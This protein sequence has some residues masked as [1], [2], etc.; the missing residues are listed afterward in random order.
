MSPKNETGEVRQAHRFDEAALADYLKR[1]ISGFSGNLMIRQF[2]YGQSNPTFLL[3]AGERSYVLRKKPPGKL[4]PSA[5]A[6]DREYRMIQALKET[7]VPVAEPLLFCEDASIIGTPFYVMAHVEGRIFRDVTASEASGPEERAAIFDSMNETMAKIHLVDYGA[8]GLGD[9]GKPGNY[10]ARQVSRW[11]RQYEASKTDDIENMDVLIKWLEDHIPEDDS[12]SIVH[13][14]V[15]LENLIIHP[16][17]PR[18][19]AVLD[20]ELSTLGHPFSDLAYNCMHYYMP[21]SKGRLSGYKG[22]DLAELGI[23]G[24][25]DYIAAYCRRTGREGISEWTF[26][27]AF[28]MFRLASII[29]GVYKRGLD[30]NASSDQARSY[31]QYVLLLADMARQLISPPHPPP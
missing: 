2:T 29:Q 13:G 28:S 30:G 22:L 23:P 4:L 19:V 17:E 11:K 18:V 27:V 6:V 25:N 1:H 26:F 20:W 3:S 21:V 10:M 12:T 31:G 24:E 5:H 7:D 14:D 16:K 9:Y 8:L 15:R